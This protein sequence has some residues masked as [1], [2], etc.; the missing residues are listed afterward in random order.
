VRKAGENQLEEFNE[1]IY[2]AT[3]FPTKIKDKGLS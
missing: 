3:N 2:G 1:R